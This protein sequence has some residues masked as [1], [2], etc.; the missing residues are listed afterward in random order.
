M[1]EAGNLLLL[2]LPESVAEGGVIQLR[3]DVRSVVYIPA[4]QAA[5]LLHLP[6]HIF[7]LLQA[8]TD[9]QHLDSTSPRPRRSSPPSPPTFS[10]N[11]HPLPRNHGAPALARVGCEGCEQV[12]QG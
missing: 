5:E 6:P 3:R 12:G 1:N 11:F 10:L 8:R 9:H 2:L 7:A 4:A